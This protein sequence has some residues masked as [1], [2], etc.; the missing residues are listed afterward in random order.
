M[1]NENRK[2][3]VLLKPSVNEIP[4]THSIVTEHCGGQ[5]LGDFQGALPLKRLGGY[6]EFRGELRGRIALPLIPF[7]PRAA[8]T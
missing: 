5:P 2:L 7:E 8:E 4:Q 1:K 3:C 6:G